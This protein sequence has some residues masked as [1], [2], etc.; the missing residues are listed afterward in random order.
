MSKLRDVEGK[1][2]VKVGRKFLLTPE[3]RDA[4]VEAIGTVRYMSLAAEAVG[5]HP[6]TAQRWMKLGEKHLLQYHP[7]GDDCTASCDEDSTALR[8]FFVAIKKARAEATK[9]GLSNLKEHAKSNWQAGAWIEE[10]TNPELFSIKS[11]VE[12]TGEGG[13]PIV[14]KLLSSSQKQA[15][16][17]SMKLQ[18]EMEENEQGVFVEK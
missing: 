18:I 10:R 14:H 2:I 11:K 7:D 5:I 12:H 9:A 13:G 4:M 17:S 16:L 8:S 15:L 6:Q 3:I 1:G